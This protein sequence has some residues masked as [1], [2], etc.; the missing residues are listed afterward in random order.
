MINRPTAAGF[1]LLKFSIG[2]VGSVSISMSTLLQLCVSGKRIRL[3]GS[4]AEFAGVDYV[5]QRRY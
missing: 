2:I 4:V 1:G 3:D 5:G